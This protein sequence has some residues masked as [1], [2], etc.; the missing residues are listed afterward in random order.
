MGRKAAAMTSTTGRSVNHARPAAMNC[1]GFTLMELVLVML[2]TCIVLALAVPSLSGFLRGR[3]AKDCAAQVLALGQ[4]ARTQAVNSGAVYRFNL[5]EMNQ[6]Y[7]LTQQRGSEFVELGTEFGRTFT[8]PKEIEA[9]WDP[10]GGGGENYID[11]YPDGRVA[12]TLLELSEKNG[13][14]SIVGCRSE[15][16]PLTILAGER[17]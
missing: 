3:K 14:R 12:A 15:T 9:R 8:L 5:D 10:T 13:E 7:W 4:Y 17:R 2:I 1:R 6:T 16:E 11:F